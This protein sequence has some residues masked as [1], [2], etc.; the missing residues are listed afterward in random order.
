MKIS[1]VIGIVVLE[2]DCG[3]KFVVNTETTKTGFIMHCTCGRVQ[4][5]SY[6]SPLTTAISFN[7]QDDKGNK[8]AMPLEEYKRMLASVILEGKKYKTPTQHKNAVNVK[9]DTA[10]HE[11]LYATLRNLGFSK[12]E[13]IAKVDLAVEHGFVRDTDIIKYILSLK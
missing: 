4:Y 10:E 11:N 7:R 13:S 12:E 9:I 1:E 3:Q 8:A 2:C 6:H 5:P